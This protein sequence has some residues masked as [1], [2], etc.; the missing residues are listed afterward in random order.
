MK[1]AFL[2]SALLA[3]VVLIAMLVVNKRVFLGLGSVDP[4]RHATRSPTVHRLDL[5]LDDGVRL[6]RYVD[7]VV[8]DRL[9]V[10]R[11]DGEVLD[12]RVAGVSV[13]SRALR[14]PRTRVELAHGGTTYEARCGMLCRDGGGIEPIVIDGVKIAVEVTRLLFSTMRRGRSPF[15]QYERFRLRGD[16]RLALWSASRELT[17]G[18][19][20][21]FIVNQ[22]PWSRARLG[23]WLHETSYGIHAGIDIFATRHGVP[24]EVICPVAGT[25]YK[26]YNRDG[27]PDSR[28][29]KAVN[30]FGDTPV[31][32][33][34][35]RVLYRFLHFSEIFVDTGD[36][37]EPGQVLGLTGHTGFDPRTGD[38]VHFEMRLSPTTLG[39]DDDGDIFATIP[40]NPYNFLLEWYE[41]GR[42]RVGEG[43]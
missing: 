43:N 30:I 19:K 22:T 27:S 17:E 21:P 38:H 7:V 33:D 24:E 15:N 40:I 2:V 14:C 1:L 3:I 11:K 29:N 36:R 9:Q 37:V 18:W 5:T 12:I 41:R 10:V 42:E 28:I 13:E 35:E 6:P 25:V 39:F 32:P 16:A 23:N 20:G 4:D 31:G 26:A 34:G 8:G